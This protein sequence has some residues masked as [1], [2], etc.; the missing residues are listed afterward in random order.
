MPISRCMCCTNYT[1]TNSVCAVRLQ[2][3]VSEQ[4]CTQYHFLHTKLT[5]WPTAPMHRP[6]LLYAL[7]VGL[8]Y[9]VYSRT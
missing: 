5:I 3:V 2:Q 8:L 4:Q 1:V 7:Y 6:T 9:N